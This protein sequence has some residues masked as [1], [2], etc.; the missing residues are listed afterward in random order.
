MMIN[1]CVWSAL[2]WVLVNY[3]TLYWRI[4]L[5]PSFTGRQR[6]SVTIKEKESETRKWFC[7]IWKINCTKGSVLQ[8]SQ[9]HHL[10]HQDT[11]AGEV[12]SQRAA[13]CGDKCLPKQVPQQRE[14]LSLLL[15]STPC[16]SPNMSRYNWECYTWLQ[17]FG[18]G[19]IE[20]SFSF[21]SA[22]SLLVEHTLFWICS[23]VKKAKTW[24]NF[25]FSKGLWAS[26]SSHL[27][28]GNSAGL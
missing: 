5:F 6:S 7:K 10:F 26:I 18:K 3:N 21:P 15:S 4:F 17:S 8:E 14:L 25:S 2:H 11:H 13:E 28:S 9:K 19:A 27:W 16:W 12:I 22:F 1:W 20:I 23:L 24:T